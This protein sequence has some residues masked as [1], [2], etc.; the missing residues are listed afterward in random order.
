MKSGI[1]GCNR[2]STPGRS[3]TVNIIKIKGAVTH[4]ECNRQST[5]AVIAVV[6]EEEWVRQ[7]LGLIRFYSSIEYLPLPAA[8]INLS[9]SK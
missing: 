4:G 1:P 7:P 3:V 9:S 6:M 8:T 2:T 5:S